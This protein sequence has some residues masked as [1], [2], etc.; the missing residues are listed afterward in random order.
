MASITFKGNPVTL[1]GSEVKVGDQ[2][3]DFTVLS[4]S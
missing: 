1:V 4:N 3:P 2:A